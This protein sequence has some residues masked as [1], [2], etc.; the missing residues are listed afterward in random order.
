M[1]TWTSSLS[2]KSC[3][4]ARLIWCL[5]T[6]SNR[7]CVLVFWRRWS[8]P[9]DSRLYLEDMQQALERITRYLQRQTFDTFEQN[10]LLVD[11]IVR[12]LELLG[13]AAKHVPQDIRSNHPSVPWTKIAGLRDILTHQYF[14]VDLQIIWDV[15]T[16]QVPTLRNAIRV[17]LE[18]EQDD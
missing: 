18:E 11:G 15:V 7:V 4:V 13:E 1:P 10:E 6:V 17:M 12:N 14:A 16:N 2:C 9:R 3:L 8:M 5:K